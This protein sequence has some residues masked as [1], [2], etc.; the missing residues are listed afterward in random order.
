VRDPDSS[1]LTATVDYGDGGGEQ[2]LSLEA[3]GSFRLIYRYRNGGRFPLTVRSA[4]ARR[5]ALQPCR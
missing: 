3:D 5:P 2:P 4:M 1:S